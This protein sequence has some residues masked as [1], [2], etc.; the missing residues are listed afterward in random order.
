MGEQFG[1]PFEIF[2]DNSAVKTLGIDFQKYEIRLS[3]EKTL[4]DAGQLV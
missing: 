1:S 2:I 4:G 3:T